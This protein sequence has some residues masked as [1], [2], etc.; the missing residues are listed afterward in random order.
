M[1]DNSHTSILRRMTDPQADEVAQSPL[2]TSRAVRM[3]MTKA[4]HSAL[5]LA[6]TVTA[7]EEGAQPLDAMLPD[8]PDDLMMVAL[9]RQGVPVGL[10]GLDMQVRAAVVELQ[11]IGR[12]GKFAP[13]FRVATSTDKQMSDRFMAALLQDLTESVAGTEFEGWLD[14]LTHQDMIVDIRAAALI[15]DDMEYRTLRMNIDLGVEGRAGQVLLALPLN[16]AEP[17]PVTPAAEK[18]PWDPS[19]RMAVAD[20]PCVLDVELH[21][22]S[23]SL[24]QAENLQVG[25]VLALPDCTVSSAQLVSTDGLVRLPAKL[26][27][28]GG[29][30]AVRIEQAPTM[31]MS[32]LGALSTDQTAAAGGPMIPDLPNPMEHDAVD[33]A[34]EE[35]DIEAA[36]DAPAIETAAFDESALEAG[37]FDPSAIETDA[38]PMDLPEIDIAPMSLELPE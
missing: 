24:A 15:L 28:M 30:R 5:G 2:T 29:K 22:F 27:Q 33:M 3:A 35:P 38:D 19:F 13:E 31:G 11:T 37:A 8:L 6:V 7:I 36:V 25:Q 18:L 21:R 1:A 9:H 26:G 12:V 34:L 16:T 20:A 23:I 4:A 14:G 10:I 17:A 32:D